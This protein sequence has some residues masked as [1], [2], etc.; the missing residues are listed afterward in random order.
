MIILVGGT[1]YRSAPGIFNPLE[2]FT[3]PL[4]PCNVL[5]SPF[6]LITETATFMGYFIHF[7]ERDM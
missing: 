3:V 4:S 2:N 5:G 1:P 7:T 6:V